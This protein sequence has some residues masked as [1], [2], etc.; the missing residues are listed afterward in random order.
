M[1]I[2]IAI[3]GFSSCGKSTLAKELAN[4]LNYIYVDSGA[5]YRAVTLHLMNTGILKDGH[6]IQKQVIQELNDITIRFAYNS[7][8]KKSETFLNGVNIE[9]DIRTLEISRHVSAISAIAEVRDKLV[10]IQQSFGLSGGVIMDGRDIGTVVFPKAEVK[11]FMVADNDVR[12]ERRFLELKNKGENLNLEDV[13]KSISRRDYLDMNRDI[14]PL[15][16]AK[17][18]VEIDNTELSETDQLELALQIIQE[19]KEALQQAN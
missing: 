11:L 18:A 5:M 2:T 1:G 6:F 19:K 7:D 14:S 10:S 8:Q 12:A 4:E 3:D 9:K 17:D 16:K 13:K 15:R